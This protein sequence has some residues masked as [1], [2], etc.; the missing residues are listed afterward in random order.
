MGALDTLMSG[1]SPS[2]TFEKVGDSIAG[3]V[4]DIDERQDHVYGEPTKLLWWNRDPGPDT[5]NKAD[6]PKMIPIFVLQT[7]L[8]DSD[9]DDGRRSI[10]CRQNCFSAVQAAIRSAFPG[11]KKLEDKQVLGGTLK[12]QFHSFGEKPKNG[13]QPAKLFRAKFDRK[14]IVETPANSG[15]NHDEQNPPPADW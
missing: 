10:W 4:V 14:A 12:V 9:E 8:K 6:R 11:V 15:A 7:T 1:G 5:G 2:F 13:F 3:E